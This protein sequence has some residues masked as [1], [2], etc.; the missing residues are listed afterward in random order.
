ME[1]GAVVA[2][3]GSLSRHPAPPRQQKERNS[4]TETSCAKAREMRNNGSPT[5]RNDTILSSASSRRTPLYFGS[6]ASFSRKSE[7]TYSVATVAIAMA[8]QSLEPPH[9]W[10]WSGAA[11]SERNE[12]GCS[13]NCSRGEIMITW[14]QQPLFTRPQD[15]PAVP[16]LKPEVRIITARGS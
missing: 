7:N 15:E 14:T 12:G 16:E 5:A 9:Q 2:A 1:M 4:P 8:E 11:P 13:E 3:R 10:E 6:A